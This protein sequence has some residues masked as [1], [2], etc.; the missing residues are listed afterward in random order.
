MAVR[1]LIC[2]AALPLIGASAYAQDGL[3]LEEIVVTAQKR[4][5]SLIEVPVAVSVFSGAVIEQAQIR[6]AIDLQQLVPSLVVNSSTG[7]TQSI[8]SIRGIGTA[9]NNT[10]LEQSVGVFIDGVYRGRV[11]A[12][13]SDYVDI[14]QIEVLRGPQSTL[15]G[16]NTSAGIIS[17]TTRKPDQEFGGIIEAAAGDFGMTQLRGSVTGPMS[18]SLSFRLSGA[19]FARDGVIK[20]VVDNRDYNNRERASVRLQLLWDLA[21]TTTLRFIGDY[22][23]I[24]DE[25]CAATPLFA[26]P[27]AAIAGALGGAGSLAGGLGE[28]DP[29]A[30]VAAHSPAAP[31]DNAFEDGGVSV[32]LNHEFAETELTIIAASRFFDTITGID[33]DFQ[34]MDLLGVR[35][36]AQ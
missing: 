36:Q 33:A 18:D 21:D 29:F 15:F 9:G 4:T 6:D 17:I 20:D 26:G 22:A 7:S 19:Y 23:D 3:V 30:R 10:G 8:F 27:T 35:A 34:R 14:E 32:E 5:E 31:F 2:G 28:V 1:V 13:M 12:A 25:C 24:K 11:G 16:K